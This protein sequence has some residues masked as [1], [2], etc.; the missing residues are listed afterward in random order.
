MPV[1]LRNDQTHHTGAPFCHLCLHRWLCSRP[2]GS[3]GKESACNTEDLAGSVPRLGRSPGRGHG[4]PLQHCSL[5]NPQGQRGLVG[6][7]PWSR[8]ESDTI[9]QLSSAQHTFTNPQ[10]LRAIRYL[11]PVTRLPLTYH[12]GQLLF[13]PTGILSFQKLAL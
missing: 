4:N 12:Q 11:P 6:Y 9:E 2:D 8:K 13:P 1:P 7:C 3:D 5:E 10:N